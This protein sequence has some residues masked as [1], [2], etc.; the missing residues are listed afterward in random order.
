MSV[1]MCVPMNMGTSVSMSGYASLCV[2]RC[3]DASVL[4]WMRRRVPGGRMGGYMAAA[5]IAQSFSS[6]F[7]LLVH[8]TGYTVYHVSH[9]FATVRLFSL[10]GRPVRFIHSFPPASDPF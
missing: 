5:A 4:G 10:T 2:T 6:Q 8:H 3:M 9:P 7:I 1:T